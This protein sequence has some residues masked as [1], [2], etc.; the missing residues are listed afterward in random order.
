[1]KRTIISILLILCIL[2]LLC[3][4][5]ETPSTETEPVATPEPTVEPSPTP[6]PEPTPTPFPDYDFEVYGCTFNTADLVIDLNHVTIED[7]GEELL[8]YLPDCHN[9][10]VLDMD[11]CGV[12]NE[13]MAGIRDAYPEV[14]VIWRVW[15]GT[16]YSV[17]T[18]V[19]KILA[20]N[21]ALGGGLF[22]NRCE[23]LN[24]C[25]KVK[26]LDVG[27]NNWL[28]DI[29]FVE[30]MPD[31]EVFI[32]AQDNAYDEGFYD[33][34]PLASCTH[35]EFLEIQGTRVFDLSPLENLTE[36]RHLNIGADIHLGSIEPI[37]NLDLERLWITC[38][39][40]I[41]W[42]QVKEFME[43]HPDCEVNNTCEVPNDGWKWGTER[44]AL[45][46]QQFGYPELD[47]QT[48]ENDPLYKE[49]ESIYTDYVSRKET[50]S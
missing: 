39:T 7:N 48:T 9:L 24:Y 17:R 40:P 41:P 32:I 36:L 2:P 13:H 49:H 26:Y 16:N 8:Q 10:E 29:S 34:T 35:L 15:F 37:M 20:S 21:P 45:L 5:G 28:H 25:T 46:Q 14:E 12:D 3:A 19:T 47:Y 4:C 31:L 44:Y 43:L 50:E 18:N 38:S 42:R 30:N 1:M 33:L 23:G 27:H 22:D 6:T 11:F